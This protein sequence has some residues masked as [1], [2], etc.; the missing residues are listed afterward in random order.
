ML[1]QHGMEDCL[2]LSASLVKL[3]K[4][5]DVGINQKESQ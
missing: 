1:L 2:I 3:A 4:P 5:L